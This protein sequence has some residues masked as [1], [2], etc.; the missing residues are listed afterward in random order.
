[1]VICL[2]DRVEYSCEK[3]DSCERNV[4]LVENQLGFNL[5]F[6]I[7]KYYLI[8]GKHDKRVKLKK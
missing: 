4:H 2:F 8:H 1:M 6:L 3:R 7:S 5:G